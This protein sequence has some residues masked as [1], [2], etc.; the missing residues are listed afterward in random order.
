MSI[1]VN[2]KNLG[3]ATAYAYYKAGGGT[4]T[5]AEFT[6]F[7]AD[8]GTASQTAVEA[9]Q[10][11]LASKNAAQ[12]AAT[13]ATNKAT[14]AT[15][16]ATTATTKA[17][18]A[19][20]SASTAT[21]AKD[22]AVSASQTA[23]SKATE[24]TTAAATA[25]SAK[26]D[27]V[28][29]NTAAQSAKTAA[30]TAQTGA[31]TAAAS[32]QSSAA[33][34]A[35]NTDDI[36]QL[37]SELTVVIDADSDKSEM[38]PDATANSYR[39]NESDGFCSVNAS[40]KMVKY[41]VTAGDLIEVKS[42]DRFQ[43]QTVASV[44]A[45]G[46]SNRVGI[47]YG[48][49]DFVL[50]VPE[51]ATYC[52]VSTT[53][54][55]STAKV[56]ALEPK[57]DAVETELADIQSKVHGDKQYLYTDK[58][59]D[60]KYWNSGGTLST[61]AQQ[62]NYHA[63]PAITLPAGT[64]YTYECGDAYS[65]KKVGN[66]VSSL[67]VEQLNYSPYRGKFVLTD[68]SIVMLTASPSHTDTSIMMLSDVTEFPSDA[69]THEFNTYFGD[70]APLLTNS[71]VVDVNGHGD[72]ANIQDA[73]DSIVGDSAAARFNIVVMPGTY[74]RFDSKKTGNSAWTERYINIIGVDVDNTIIESDVGLYSKATNLR[75]NGVVK[76]ITFKMTN[77]NQGDVSQ[78]SY[79]YAYA[80]H[81]DFGQQHCRFENCK[82]IST[83]GPA[84][85][86][87]I[88]NDSYLEFV[89]C[90]FECNQNSA[91]GTSSLGALFG[92]ATNSPNATGIRL[93]THN[94]ICNNKTGDN[95]AVITTLVDST[96]QS[97]V[98]T[99]SVYVGTGGGAISVTGTWDKGYSAN[100]NVTI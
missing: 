66:T 11:A 58:W 67:N 80:V 63:Y 99:N 61:S 87:G 49:G 57:I 59:L 10:A 83:N 82:F 62:Y 9:A 64:Y 43:F 7:M 34:I 53:I 12:T 60:H 96:V 13:T 45:S 77:T 54:D 28:A 74:P 76:N 35:T 55:N 79:N 24:A 69:T 78:E 39:L 16:A 5:E 32:V 98:S 46:T 72:F 88:T 92:H 48:T 38:T 23:T 27:A 85:G 29:A 93:E 52:I 75:L 47:T 65:F 18:E 71:I 91:V 37:K 81:A 51:T 2:D 73:I 95:G 42:D 56:Y 25:T 20:T 33:Q 40:Y 90:Y 94:C 84:V 50:T 22:T 100:N 8:F 68:E 44:P 41:P 3:H 15:T 89:G 36:A 86:F 17:G 70:F 31:E 6:E 14:E 1:N 30:Q 97:F 19:S 21:S 4:M 26:T